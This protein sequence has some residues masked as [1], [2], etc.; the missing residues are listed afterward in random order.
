MV[1]MVIMIVVI[2]GV[3]FALGNTEEIRSAVI[4]MLLVMLGSGA[5]KFARASDSVPLKDYVNE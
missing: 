3:L 2:I 1:P 5:D 4:P